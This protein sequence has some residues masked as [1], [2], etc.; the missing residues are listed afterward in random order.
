MNTALSV[1]GSPAICTGHDSTTGTIKVSATKVTA[2]NPLLT[3]TACFDLHPPELPRGRLSGICFRPNWRSLLTIAT[4]LNR[5]RSF[6][7]DIRGS[8]RHCG[9][10]LSEVD[11]VGEPVAIMLGTWGDVRLL[12][13]ERSTRVLIRTCTPVLT[14]AVVSFE[15]PCGP[16]AFTEVME[17][18][19]D[20][21]ARAHHLP[22]PR[23]SPRSPRV[24]KRR[25]FTL[26]EVLEQP[27]EKTWY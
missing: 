8:L 20:A 2:G 7:G 22:V 23:P 10:P 6:A 25:E 1:P 19:C 21:H 24:W 4:I 27:P 16:T 14:G 18:I 5:W 11:M 12:H 9:I 3:S 15:N 26:L 13:D 17:C